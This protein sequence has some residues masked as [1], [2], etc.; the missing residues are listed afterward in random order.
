MLSSVIQVAAMAVRV[1]EH[2]CKPTQ[3]YNQ[4]DKADG[5]RVI[6]TLGKKLRRLFFLWLLVCIASSAQAEFAPGVVNH[7][8]TKKERTKGNTIVSG[9]PC[10]L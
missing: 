10:H 7:V 3:S 8:P 9:Q 4:P 5:R 1:T 2:I 6:S